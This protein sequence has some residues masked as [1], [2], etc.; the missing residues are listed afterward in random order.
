VR[1]AL[2]LIAA[3]VVL[4]TPTGAQAD[5]PD[6]GRPG[7]DTTAQRVMSDQKYARQAV[8]ATN[9]QRAK[10]GLRTLGVN[11]CLRKFAARQAQ[12][13][14]NS[15]E[16]FHQDLGPI[17]G[18]CRKR[19]AGENVAFGLS[20]GRSAVQAWMNS[21]GHRDNILNRS[22]RQVG[23]AAREGVD[24]RWYVAQVFGG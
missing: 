9:K 11:P 14:A 20:S 21:Q 16:L 2:L 24:G 8:R 1:R 4:L 13:M 3:L 23:I 15:A 7:T 18:T 6:P 10:F 12:A 17:L 5:Q 19:T 22:Y